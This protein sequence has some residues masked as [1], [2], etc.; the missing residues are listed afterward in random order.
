[1]SLTPQSLKEWIEGSGV[2]EAIAHLN[3]EYL[4][5]YAPFD[6]LF[7]SDKIQRLNTGRLPGWILKRY[8]H[9]EQG[10]WWASGIDPLTGEAEDWGCFKPDHPRID[11]TKGKYQKYEHPLKATATL[12]ALRVPLHIWQMVSK[13][14]SVPMPANLVVD[15]K[16]E[17]LGFWA[18]VI[19]HPKVSVT[20]TAGVCGDWAAWNLGSLPQK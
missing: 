14:C 10:G 5:G 2:D 1:M 16:G 17:A 4:E 18:W 8:R 6:R 3:V 12:F 9:I 19:A 20:L 7:Y 13:R 15:A 11:P